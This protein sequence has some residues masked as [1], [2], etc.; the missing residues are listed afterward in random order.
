MLSKAPERIRLSSTR[1]FRSRPSIRSQK[2]ENEA[3]GPPAARSSSTFWAKPRPTPLSA[4]RPKRMSGPETVKSAPDPFTSGG[5]R[6]MPIARHS[7]MY[8]AT[9]SCT[10]RTEVSSAAMYARGW[11]HL[12]QAV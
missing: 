2:S 10:S 7:A 9:L 11:W 6:R 3:N 5:S 1:L 8:S 4:A 12:D